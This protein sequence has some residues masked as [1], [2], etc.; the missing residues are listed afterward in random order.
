M[1]LLD[2]SGQGP[3]PI[4]SRGLYF[5]AQPWSGKDKSGEAGGQ[6]RAADVEQF[7]GSDFPS[8]R[9]LMQLV[10]PESP[11]AVVYAAEA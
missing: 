1:E 5:L 7:G 9:L 4:R 11:V 10:Q 6:L 3:E 8:V 2:G